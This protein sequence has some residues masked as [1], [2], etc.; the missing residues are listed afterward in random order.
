MKNDNYLSEEISGLK[1]DIDSNTESLNSI[2]ES[3]ALQIKNGLGNK[4]KEDMKPK[5]LTFKDKV[6]IFFN[7]LINVYG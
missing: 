6:K 1:R 4:I 2:K 7:K 5:K 3:Y